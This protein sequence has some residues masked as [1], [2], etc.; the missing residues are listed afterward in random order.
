MTFIGLQIWMGLFRAPKLADYW[1]KKKIY[2]NQIAGVMSRNRFELLLANW[3]F[4]DNQTA[5]TSD[6]LYKLGPLLEQLRTNFQ[7]YFIPK[8]QICVDET[9]VPFRGRLA[10]IQYIKNKGTSSE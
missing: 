9:L 4:Q 10:F 3:H 1:S 7:K 5:D 2:V 6:R 8:D